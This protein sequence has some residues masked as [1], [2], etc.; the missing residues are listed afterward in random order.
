M[1]RSTADTKK[2]VLSSHFVELSRQ[3][4]TTDLLEVLLSSDDYDLKHCIH[5][6]PICKLNRQLPTQ[7]YWLGKHEFCI[8]RPET[9]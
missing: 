1:E 4:L 6:K 5:H 3:S 2:E 7:P 9:C 8:I